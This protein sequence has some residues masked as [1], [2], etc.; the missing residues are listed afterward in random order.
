M[1]TSSR[2]AAEGAD[3]TT[4]T[5]NTL[6][7]VRHLRS[8]AE[9]FRARRRTAQG[10]AGRQ[11]VAAGA[12]H[13]AAYRRDPELYALAALADRARPEQRARVLFRL[14]AQS[15]AGVAAPLR[16]T[17]DRVTARLATALPAD[18]VLAVFLALR[19]ARAN[20]KH[21]RRAVVRYL[22]NHPRLAA[23]ARRRRPAVVDCLEHALGRD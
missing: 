10:H 18:D 21:V 7:F 14:L 20:H 22:L 23:L 11:A 8:A 3:V 16:L 4:Q 6:A 2:P 13:D 15:R 5:T 12:A 9:P 17:L 19:R 1:T